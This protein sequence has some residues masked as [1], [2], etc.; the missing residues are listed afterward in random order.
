MRA[1]FYYLMKSPAVYRKVLVEIDEAAAQGKLS[2]PI[3]YA[4]A[5]ELPY[6]CACIKEAMRLHPSVGLAMPRHAPSEGLDLNNH[7]IPAGYRVGI[8]AAVAHQDP[9]KFG[10]EPE[11]FAPERWLEGDSK[12]MDRYMLHFGAGTRTCIGK[13]VRRQISLLIQMLT[14]VIRSHLVNC[15]N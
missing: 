1:V 9:A 12:E 6:L 5:I 11:K 7:H 13:N 2:T 10:A 3:K 14:M 8:N 4:E 15:T